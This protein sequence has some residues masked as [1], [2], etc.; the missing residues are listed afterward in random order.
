MRSDHRE[1]A[2]AARTRLLLVD[3]EAA[4]TDSL[5]PFLERSGFDVRVAADGVA[6]LDEF[7]RWRPDVVVC[8]VLM[9]RMDGRELVRRLRSNA[10]WT[11]ILLLTKVGESFERSAALDEGADDYL[12]KPFDPQELLSRV[13]AVVRRVVA[14]RP[15]LTTV[16]RLV[17]GDLQFDRTTRR[18]RLAGMEVVLT[19]RAALLLEYLMS[20][21]DE[22]H[23]RESLLRALWGFDFVASTRAIDHRIAEIRRVLR[24]DAA[25]PLFIETVQTIGYRFVGAV[26]RG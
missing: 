1:P 18:I 21:P 7:D 13:R 9:P 19:P 25:S 24:D 26:G 8:D 15:P 12:N 20:R 2:A 23:S 17:S 3:D 16:E 22:V 5:T 11:P 6:A 4:I 10:D 14:G